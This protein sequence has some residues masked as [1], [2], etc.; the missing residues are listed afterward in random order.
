MRAE[1]YEGLIAS[2]V[3]GTLRQKDIDRVETMI[4]ADAQL[5]QIYMEKKQQKDF[6]LQLIPQYTLSKNM[7]AQIYAEMKA[8]NADVFP[9]DRNHYLKKIKDFLDRPIAEF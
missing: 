4:A 8:I 3:N 1:H 7:K 6:Y 5:N 2:Y 9:K